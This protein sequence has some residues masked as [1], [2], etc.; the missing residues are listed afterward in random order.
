[1]FDCR[2]LTFQ[3]IFL[4]FLHLP[5]TYQGEISGE[6]IFNTD[7]YDFPFSAALSTGPPQNPLQ[8]ISYLTSSADLHKILAPEEFLFL[9]GETSSQGHPTKL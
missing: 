2:F 9:T 5:V 7:E 1:M 3:V 4:N 8:G 6:H